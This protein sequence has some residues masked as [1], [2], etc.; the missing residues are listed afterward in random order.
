MSVYTNKGVRLL[1]D[2]A[3]HLRLLGSEYL[4]L[5]SMCYVHFDGT[6]QICLRYSSILHCPTASCQLLIVLSP[7]QLELFDSFLEIELTWFLTSH[8]TLYCS[9][10]C[11]L[12]SANRYMFLRDIDRL[13]GEKPHVSLSSLCLLT[14]ANRTQVSGSD[15]HLVGFRP[16]LKHKPFEAAYSD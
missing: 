2:I 1:K 4:I 6:F 13:L 14:R 15:R 8:Q 10:Y 3:Q 7:K 5:W 12:A 16:Q 11:C 9:R